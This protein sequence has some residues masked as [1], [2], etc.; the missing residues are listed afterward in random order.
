EVALR[1]PAQELW[2]RGARRAPG[3][4]LLAGEG[5]AFG[6]QFLQQRCWLERV[7]EALL[8]GAQ[9]IDD[10]FQADRVAPQHRAPPVER[11]SVAVDPYDVDVAS[12]QGDALLEDLRSFV[13]HGIEAALE[14]LVVAEGT[15]LEAADLRVF[16]NEI[17]HHRIDA[18]LAGLGI[19]VVEALS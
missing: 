17:A 16:A 15:R 12:A 6:G 2:E 18:A 8:V 14:D 7:A 11:P 19:V 3:R 4:C 13:D 10:L 5:L 1:A 9:A